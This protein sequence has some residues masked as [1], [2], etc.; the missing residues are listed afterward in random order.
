VLI[1]DIVDPSVEA[2]DGCPAWD[3]KHQGC[4]EGHGNA[5]NCPQH[6]GGAE[7]VRKI[8]AETDIGETSGD[9]AEK[10][11]SLKTQKCHVLECVNETE[12]GS[13]WCKD[14]Q[15]KETRKGERLPERPKDS[16]RCSL[17][18]RVSF[19]AEPEEVALIWAF[20]HIASDEDG[21]HRNAMVKIA[22]L[23]KHELLAYFEESDL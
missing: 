13:H 16:L 11:P 4:L 7:A 17:C 9:I 14:H 12:A 6:N 19:S 1:V 2:C 8:R 23:V 3:L 5:A 20:K 21:A 22:R 15:T 10:V 18:K